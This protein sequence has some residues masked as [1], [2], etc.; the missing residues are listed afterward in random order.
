MNQGSTMATM[1]SQP[2]ISAPLTKSVSSAWTKC[3]AGASV[4]AMGMAT[5]VLSTIRPQ[6]RRSAVIQSMGGKYTRR[7]VSSN[8]GQPPAAER[9]EIADHIDDGADGQQSGQQ[10]GPD[11]LGSGFVRLRGLSLLH[12]LSP[13]VTQKVH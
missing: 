1:Q 10:S 5:R 4:M 8:R 3:Q 7:A 2:S 13:I 12:D 11:L 6:R 9:D